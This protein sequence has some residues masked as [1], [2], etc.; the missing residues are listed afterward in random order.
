MFEANNIL[1]AVLTPRE[2]SRISNFTIDCDFKVA[3]LYFNS[4]LQIWLMIL[5]SLMC[6][7]RIVIPHILL[8]FTL[9]VLVKHTSKLLL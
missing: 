2:K 5:H 8:N 3:K 4:M 6:N 1:N 9:N 7:M